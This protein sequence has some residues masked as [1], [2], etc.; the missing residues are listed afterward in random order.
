MR[1]DRARSLSVG[2]SLNQPSTAS[3]V[4]LVHLPFIPRP[5][6]PPCHLANHG[7]QANAV[8]LPSPEGC[9]PVVVRFD[10]GHTKG[11]QYTEGGPMEAQAVRH[12]H[13]PRL[14]SWLVLALS[15]SLVTTDHPFSHPRQREQLRR[16]QTTTW[17]VNR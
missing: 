7:A 1:Q 8:P 13:E 6:S 15:S 16:G 14:L 5:L 2:R 11:K 12:K 17:R 3:V 9:G 4:D 10:G